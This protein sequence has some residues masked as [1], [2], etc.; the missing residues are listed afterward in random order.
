MHQTVKSFGLCSKFEKPVIFA[1][2]RCHKSMFDLICQY[3]CAYLTTRTSDLN[4]HNNAGEGLGWTLYVCGD[5]IL[6]LYLLEVYRGD[7]CLIW[8]EGG[9]RW[10]DKL[11][12][13]FP[14]PDREMLYSVLLSM[15]K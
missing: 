3:V 13:C 10:N 2:L 7:L 9:R 14:S 4:V 5:Y 11:R 6:L 8:W 1:G 12:P 15:R